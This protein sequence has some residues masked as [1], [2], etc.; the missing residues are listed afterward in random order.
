M[1]KNKTYFSIYYSFYSL[2]RADWIFFNL[3]SNS[4]FFTNTRGVACCTVS[5]SCIIL[6]CGFFSYYRSARSNW[7]QPPYTHND[8]M[9]N[10]YWW[11]RICHVARACSLFLFTLVQ[12]AVSTLTAFKNYS[13][14]IKHS[15]SF[16]RYYFLDYRT[17]EQPCNAKQN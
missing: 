8:L 12:N 16:K 2:L 3:H 1:E 17:R 14:W 4:L 15:T 11:H 9:L 6:Q 13:L 7:N 10:A 5:W